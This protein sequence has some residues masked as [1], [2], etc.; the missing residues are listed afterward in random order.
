MLL[1]CLSAPLTANLAA[2]VFSHVIYGLQ[3]ALRPWLDLLHDF[4]STQIPGS[5]FYSAEENSS[6]NMSLSD[7]L[8]CRGIHS[9]HTA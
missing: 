5:C 4:A 1:P 2:G 3:Y 9:S 7:L 8:T 6:M